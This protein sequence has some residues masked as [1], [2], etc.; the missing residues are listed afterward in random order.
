MSLPLFIEWQAYG[1]LNPFTSWRDDWRFAMLAS[2]LLTAI[3]GSS[4]RV[5]KQPPKF[6]LSK[7]I[8]NFGTIH[9]KSPTEIYSIIRTAAI[10]AMGA[11]PPTKKFDKK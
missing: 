5:Y 3:Y 2:N 7:F 11:K 9:K 6:K 4:G 10:L 1:R 8:P